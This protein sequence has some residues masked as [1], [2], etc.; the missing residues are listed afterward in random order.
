MLAER[1]TQ[2]MIERGC[3]GRVCTGFSIVCSALGTTSY[4]RQS[5]DRS[6]SPSPERIDL[7]EWNADRVRQLRALRTK[8]RSWAVTFQA[9]A[10][11][12][13]DHGIG[14]RR[15]RLTRIFEPVL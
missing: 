1:F 8:P 2:G 9:A 14:H 4:R 5:S 10:P 3:Q 11:E 13:E 12:L 6:P 15:R 7:A